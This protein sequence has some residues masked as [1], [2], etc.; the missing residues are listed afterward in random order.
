MEGDDVCREERVGDN[1]IELE[2]EGDKEEE[3]D[4]DG[5]PDWVSAGENVCSELMVETAVLMAVVFELR[6]LGTEE[7][8]IGEEESGFV[9]EL[10]IDWVEKI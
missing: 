3:M 1:E 9:G 4:K 10:R 2:V 5:E 7:V 6:V 8:H